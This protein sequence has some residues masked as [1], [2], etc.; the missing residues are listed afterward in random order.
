MLFGLRSTESWATKSPPY[1]TELV[2]WLASAA[3][4]SR[5]SPREEVKLHESGEAV[6]RRGGGR[7]TPKVE[8]G[9]QREE[10]SRCRPFLDRLLHIESNHLS[11]FVVVVFLRLR[12]ESRH[13][14]L[15]R[16]FDAD[17]TFPT[18][19]FRTEP[20]HRFPDRSMD[21]EPA[22]QFGN[23][24]SCQRAGSSQGAPDRVNKVCFDWQAGRCNR[25]S[26]RFLHSELPQ[27]MSTDGATS[28]RGHHQG[29]VRGN[30]GAAGAPIS[31]WGKGRTG[32]KASDKICRYFIGGNCCYGDK[33]RFLHS[34][35]IGDS[36]SLLATLQGHRNVVTG[37]ALSSESDKLYSGS[38]DESVRVWDSQ[39][40]QCTGVFNVGGEVGCMISE[41]AWIFIGVPNAVKDAH[42]LA[43]KFNVA[44]NC[45]E[46]A[47][48]L[49]GHRLA[50]VS[51]VVG[52]MRLY[53][54]S[55]DHTIKVWDLATL[56]CLQTLTDHTSVVMSLLCW[57]QFLLSSSLDRTIKVWA[58][59]ESGNLEVKYIHNE[60]HGVLVLCGMHDAQAKPVLLCSCN[61]KSI[62]IY[63]LPSFIERG[64]IFSKK[65]VIAME[66][67][68]SDLFF[69]GDGTGELKVWKWSTNKMPVS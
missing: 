29:L 49:N 4:A 26:C 69:T 1:E 37:I 12:A 55:M 31:G 32:R 54:G 9:G 67:G 47:A 21:I 22:D 44:G 27:P 63:D 62:H 41:G 17:S 51:L 20:H 43:W 7:K 34:W 33:C 39:T 15:D 25:H 64:K 48:S 5:T 14:F 13:P 66:V 57:D 16:S 50:V 52:D 58:A 6:D 3:A 53:S 36:F 59:T 11:F 56:Q 28:R 45:F 61:D 42:I 38:K 18:L 24:R 10:L 60:E 68:P 30:S 46:P 8:G 23:N 35:F 65:E 19:G 2:A 40:G